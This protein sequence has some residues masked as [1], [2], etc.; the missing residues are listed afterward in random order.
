M[1]LLTTVVLFFG[2]LNVAT[3]FDGAGIGLDPAPGGV[4]LG[5]CEIYMGKY[6]AG[7]LDVF[8]DFVAQLRP[9]WFN[10]SIGNSPFPAGT[11]SES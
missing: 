11:I 8:L 9:G 3:A 5:T 2:G 10:G 4:K 1:R 7:T 6:T